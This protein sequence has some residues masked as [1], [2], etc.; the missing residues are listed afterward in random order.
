MGGPFLLAEKRSPGQNGKVFG[1]AFFKKL[2]G[3]KGGGA[4]FCAALCAALFAM[5]SKI[6]NAKQIKFRASQNS[7][8]FFGGPRSQGPLRAGKRANANLACSEGFFCARRAAPC[9]GLVVLAWPAA[10]VAVFALGTPGIFLPVCRCLVPGLR[11]ACCF[12]A[13]SGLC[14]RGLLAVCPPCALCVRAFF[15]LSFAFS[16]LTLPLKILFTC[17][18]GR[19]GPLLSSEKKVDKDSRGERRA[20]PLR[21]PLTVPCGCSPPL[22]RCWPA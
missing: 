7:E 4:P 18:S 19:D 9:G 6:R 17:R 14:C 12:C 1:Q 15:S 3:R 22:S 10:A 5:Q 8:A 20:A 16:C 2:A 11:A 21:T 13:W